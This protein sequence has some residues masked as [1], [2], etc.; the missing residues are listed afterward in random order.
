MPDE[1]LE[2]P[3]LVP[4]WLTII[5]IALALF[6]AFALVSWVVN[7]AFGIAKLLLLVVLVVLVVAAVRAVTRRR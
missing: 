3:S 6:G 5:V 1:D 7:F 4:L 2:R